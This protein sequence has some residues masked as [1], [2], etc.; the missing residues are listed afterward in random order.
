MDAKPRVAQHVGNRPRLL[1]VGESRSVGTRA[2]ELRSNMT[3]DKNP[4]AQS[5][6]NS[7]SMEEMGNLR[8]SGAGARP[9]LLNQL[10]PLDSLCWCCTR[11]VLTT[12]T[13]QNRFWSPVLVTGTSLK[14]LFGCLAG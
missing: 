12:V 1:L 11:S 3:A 6:Q 8:A 2:T 4:S 9:S 14:G 5:K 13:R 7:A 10:D